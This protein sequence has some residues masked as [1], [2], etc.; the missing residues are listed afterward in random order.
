MAAGRMKKNRREK[1]KLLFLSAHFSY[2]PFTRSQVRRV[3]VYFFFFAT[4]LFPFQV[5]TV[6]HFFQERTY[7]WA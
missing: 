6:V 3:T 2:R 1:L 7:T 4:S 5:F